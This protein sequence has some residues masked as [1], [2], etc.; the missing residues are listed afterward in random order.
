MESD[1][2]EDDN[3][4]GENEASKLEQ[5]NADAAATQAFDDAAV[6]SDDLE[7]DNEDGENEASKLEQP[8][9]DAAATSI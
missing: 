7:D 5:P 8:N 6:E 1:D 4:D 2:L 9:A 3:E